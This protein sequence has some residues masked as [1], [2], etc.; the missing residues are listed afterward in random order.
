MRV[1]YTFFLMEQ[2]SLCIL[3][4]ISDFGG[5]KLRVDNLCSMRSTPLFFLPPCPFFITNSGTYMV[6]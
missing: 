1:V 3:I 2:I 5:L 6:H 4:F